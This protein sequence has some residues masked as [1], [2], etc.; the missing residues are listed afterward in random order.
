MKPQSKK[1]SKSP[2][3]NRLVVQPC[4]CCGADEIS[5]VDRARNNE[6]N[7]QRKFSAMLRPL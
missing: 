3:R 5:G 1:S 2:T 4:L 7:Q 6:S